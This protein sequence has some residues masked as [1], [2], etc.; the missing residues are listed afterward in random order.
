MRTSGSA[1]LSA[2][3]RKLRALSVFGGWILLVLLCSL[4]QKIKNRRLARLQ[5]KTN[6]EELKK[7][8]E[9]DTHGRPFFK[10]KA[11]LP[12]RSPSM[13]DLGKGATASLH[14]S[15][16]AVSTLA[17]TTTVKKPEPVVMRREKDAWKEGTVVAAGLDAE[18]AGVADLTLEKE[19]GRRDDEKA[20]FKLF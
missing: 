17:P 4:H 6:R 20:P 12:K 5:K 8:V 3:L 18:A 10:R 13:P 19:E 15:G 11:L 2:E 9:F 16:V 14:D 1:I 7:N